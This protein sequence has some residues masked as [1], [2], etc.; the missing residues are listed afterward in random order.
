MNIFSEEIEQ[1]STQV[2]EGAR[3][4]SGNVEKF[5]E[6][7]NGTLRR[8]LSKRHHLV[9]GRRGSGKSSL[10]YKTYQTLTDSNHATAYIDLEPF[11][12][13]QYP[14]VVL[15]VLISTLKKIQLWLRDNKSEL[16]GERIWYT[17]WLSKKN[18]GKITP[19]IK[20]IDKEIEEL[21]VQLNLTDSAT[22]KNIVKSGNEHKRDESISGKAKGKIKGV[23]TTAKSELDT[24]I[25]NEVKSR[26]SNEITENYIRDKQQFLLRRV[27][28]YQEIFSKIQSLTDKDIYLIFDDLYHLKRENQPQIID[29]FHRLAKGNSIWLKIGTIRYRSKWYIHTPQP[30]GI[31]IGD[32]TE[33]INLD[34]TLSKF[35]TTKKFL[36]SVLEKYISNAKSPSTNELLTEGAIDRL[37]LASGGVARDF[38]GIFRRS[39]D[40]AKERLS[41]NLDHHRGSR[42]SA[43]DVNKAS[44]SY[45]ETKQEEFQ[46]DTL[47]ESA[48]L[49]MEFKKIK[50]FI[51]HTKRNVFLI[52]QEL[53]ND[54][55]DQINELIDLRLIHEIRNRVTVT[56][57]PGKVYRAYILDVSQYTGERARRDVEIMEFWKDSNKDRIRIASLIYE[58]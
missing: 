20:S 53:A 37:V 25:A 26:S 55:V 22:L 46:R 2:E 6:P 56:S 1:L 17:L 42:I 19:I 51:S 18:G 43:E 28:T 8:A 41:N 32:D 16:E 4:T 5:I 54:Q 15:S 44:G 7:A 33:E 52:D 36:I 35:A 23:F 24:K 40:E 38:L 49:E 13:H 30:I 34:V 57:K 39:L 58:P 21:I 14:D 48:P 45:G 12:G 9:F 31:K 27:I 10:L 11:K 50:D 29:Y 3:A 47:E